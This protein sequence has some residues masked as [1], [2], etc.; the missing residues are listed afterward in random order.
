MTA[1]LCRRGYLQLFI[2][3]IGLEVGIF[4]RPVVTVTEKTF[5]VPKPK[6][7]KEI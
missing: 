3:S 5:D 6:I 1:E 7:H 2:T 4:P